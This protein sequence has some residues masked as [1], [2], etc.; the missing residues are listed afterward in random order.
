MI[1]HLWTFFTCGKS[2]PVRL[3]QPVV[4]N[5]MHDTERGF[6]QEAVKVVAFTLKMS[7]Y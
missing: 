4:I 6:K 1:L 3:L 7:V 2:Q 5:R